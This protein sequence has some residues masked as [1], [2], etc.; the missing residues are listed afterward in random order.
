MITTT[1][2][3]DHIYHETDDGSSIP[4][5]VLSHSFGHKT[6]WFPWCTYCHEIFC[7]LVIDRLFPG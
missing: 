7:R 1:A 5:Q 3:D 4:G 2:T 6:S